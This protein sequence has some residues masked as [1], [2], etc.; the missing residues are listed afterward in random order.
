M[1]TL[2]LTT[3]STTRPDA[4]KD[5]QEFSK[6]RKMPVLQNPRHEKFCELVVSGIRPS[7]A[8]T[9]IGYSAGGADQ[10]ASRLLKRDDIRAR[11]SE[12]SNAAQQSAVERCSLT[13]SWVIES[14][15]SVAQRCMQVEP[16]IDGNGR[17]VGVFKFNAAGATRALELLG[18]EVGMFVERTQDVEIDF[19]N[20]T[21]SQMAKVQAWLEEQAFKDDPA[22]LEEWRRGE[23]RS[24]DEPIQ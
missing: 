4:N 19:D 5:F 21:P 13:R 23:P 2:S 12:L 14:L 3:R 1:L 9:S 6:L 17:T 18:R 11:V 20:L 22:G 24:P 8:Y 10:A 15:K 7:A 16:V